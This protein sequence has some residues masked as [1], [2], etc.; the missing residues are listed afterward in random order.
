MSA[1]L[2][3]DLADDE[4]RTDPLQHYRC[5]GP[6]AE[7]ICR[8][9]GETGIY[10]HGANK[11]SKSTT[12]AAIIVAMARGAPHLAAFDGSPIQLPTPR[13]DPR[14]TIG[15]GM[16]SYKLG[17]DSI[18]A[19]IKA[20]LGDWPHY[21]DR[22]SRAIYVKHARSRSES[23]YSK[24][25][26][27]PYEGPPPDGPRWDAFFADETPP[28][29]WLRGAFNRGKRGKTLYWAILATP[30]DE[31]IW[32]PLLKLFPARERVIVNGFAR[33]QA[34]VY[35]NRFLHLR[36]CPGYYRAA[37]NCGCSCPDI[38]QAERLNANSPW[39]K[40]ALLGEHVNVVGGCPFTHPVDLITPWEA[41]CRPAIGTRTMVV[42]KE[43]RDG[44]ELEAIQMVL[45]V[46]GDY[47]P[48][49]EYLVLADT[50]GGINDG[51]HDPDGLHVRSRRTRALVARMVPEYLG[52]W[53]LT[54]ASIATAKL[55]G[56]AKICP[57][58]GHAGPQVLS[59][60]RV[61]GWRNFGHDVKPQRARQIDPHMGITESQRSRLDAMNAVIV[62]LQRGETDMP[63]LD[64]FQCFRNCIVDG[65]GKIVARPG[66]HDEDLVLT[67]HGE[68]MLD[69]LQALTPIRKPAE[70]TSMEAF[71]QALED[72]F[73]RP[74][75]RRHR[76]SPLDDLQTWD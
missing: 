25:V 39:W 17:E 48:L 70:K 36:S 50:G 75:I 40:A 71:G 51:R 56:N 73:G 13:P 42:E 54:C 30:V 63:C 69:S 32:G 28:Q 22:V 14:I 2:A 55:Y 67:C 52:P 34:S 37:G 6:H 7:W 41:R 3:Y 59:N 33:V 45:E 53:G 5:A 19:A 47:D 38:A 16:P 43:R 44:P 26:F 18:I 64:V 20:L 58:M 65:S 10:A 49:D 29:N 12:A 60:A 62:M 61:M 24:I 35:D 21:E 68:R 11:S 23:D 76:T 31:R 8:H 46:W 57:L 15:V 27:Y 72:A 4:R 1:S 9:I 66:H 74:V